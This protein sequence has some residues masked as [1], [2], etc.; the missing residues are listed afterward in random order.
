MAREENESNESKRASRLYRNAKACSRVTEQ[1]SVTVISKCEGMLPSYI[2]WPSAPP[3]VD[4]DKKPPCGGGMHRRL[5]RR[6]CRSRTAQRRPAGRAQTGRIR[7]CALALTRVWRLFMK[8][9]HFLVKVTL[10]CF[11]FPVLSRTQKKPA[12]SAGHGRGCLFVPTSSLPSWLPN[13][14][15][16]GFV[17]STTKRISIQA[18]TNAFL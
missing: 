14:L 16:V 15:F 3:R 17:A 10:P 6:R 8:A 12:D 11:K 2:T 18:Y 1:K 7:S 9:L 5:P 4:R 13:K